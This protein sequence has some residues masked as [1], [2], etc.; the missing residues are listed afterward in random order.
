MKVLPLIFFG[1]IFV[2]AHSQ[3][4]WTIYNDI[5]SPLPTNNV[6]CVK[7]DAL[8]RKWVATDYG[9]AIFDDVSWTTYNTS[10]SNIPGNYVQSIE[11]D[12][13]GNAWIGTIEGGVGM[14]DG[15][16]WT[17]YSPLNSPLPGYDIKA[18]VID[19]GNIKWFGSSGGLIKFDGTTWTV[20]DIFNTPALLSHS[21]TSIAIG[22]DNIKRIGT[23]N[24][25]MAYYN[26]TAFTVYSLWTSTFPENTVLHIALDSNGNR[27]AAMPSAGMIAHYGA[28]A[29]SP[30]SQL[31][32]NL[33]CDAIDWVF[34][35]KQQKKYI[36]TMQ[37]GLVILTSSTT[38]V[39]Y[40][41]TN[42]PLPDD[43]VNTIAKDTN[44]IVWV[45]C[46]TGGLVRLDESILN[47]I[48]E[49]S[50]AG[51]ILNVFPNPNSGNF[52][53]NIPEGTETY[54]IQV[55]D[56]VGRKVY[57]NKEENNGG[58]FTLALKPGSYFIRAILDNKIYAGKFIVK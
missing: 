18:I 40:D 51:N 26:D 22:K 7:V 3:S 23:I 14:F 47:T 39:Y 30:Y 53:I 27:W 58:V 49:M 13:L 25:G 4:A 24:G 42:S 32:G 20:W 2:S 29:W 11:F 52:S 37:K 15:T 19:T 56:I 36:G 50:I 48:N 1:S 12:K 8:N 33:P 21:I 6:R 10:N 41:S 45:G 28:T 34:I 17:N 35:D 16:T 44:N 43:W 9:L 57:E 46:R 55:T 54:S 5:N 31:I 38:Y